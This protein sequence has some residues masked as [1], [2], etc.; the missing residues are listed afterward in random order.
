M[1]KQKI[2]ICP[3]CGSVNWKIPPYFKGSGLPIVKLCGDCGYTG[4][5]LESDS[6]KVKDTQNKLKEKNKK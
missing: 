5:F 6:D 4:T 1:K 2:F 3:K